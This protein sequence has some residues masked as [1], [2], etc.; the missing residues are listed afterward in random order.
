NGFAVLMADYYWDFKDLPK[1][2][3]GGLAEAYNWMAMVESGVDHL[4]S[5]G[6]VDKARVG[7]IGFSRTSWKT[8]FMLTHSDFKF[9]AV[10]SADSGIYNYAQYGFSNEHS[11]QAEEDKMMGGPPFGATL[12]NWLKYA[13]AF[14]AQ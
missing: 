7:V 3:P 10:S 13:P 1:G 12:E 11:W 6:I 5:Q 9:A 8:D 2:F 4:A 14:N